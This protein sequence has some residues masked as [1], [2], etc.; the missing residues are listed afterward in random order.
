MTAACQVGFL[1][2]AFLRPDLGLGKTVV[3]H[4]RDVR[5][6]DI[7]ATAA[8]D[9]VEQVVVLRLVEV[10]GAGVPEDLLRQQL[11]RA[12]LDAFSTADARPFRGVCGH[13]V[14][15]GR[16]QAVRCLGH[17]DLVVLHRKAHHRAAEYQLPHR[18]AVSAGLRDHEIRGAADR[19][20]EVAGLADTAAGDR[21]H[22]LDQ[23]P[24]AQ[25]RIGHSDRGGDVLAQH[26][27]R[28]GQ[29]M[30]R[31]LAAGQQPDQLLLAT[32]RVK[33]W[34]DDDFG[35]RI[36][37]GGQRLAQRFGG[38]RLVV[39][40]T[41]QAL[42]G[43][44]QMAQDADALDHVGRLLTHQHVVAGDVGLALSGIDDQGV[45]RALAAGVDLDRCREGG[46]AEPDDAGPAD[47]FAQVGSGQGGVVGHGF[48]QV[49]PGILAVGL[50]HDTGVVQA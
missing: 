44:D 12:H 26:A 10:V 13:L 40:D 34:D 50:D 28:R 25:H 42:P 38:L 46:A 30:R 27:D 6:A 43:T 9:A 32:T 8:F 36:G 18:V 37:L 47:A 33:R 11:G 49:G 14:L 29:P 48:R 5:R 16:E 4:Q 22:A 1:A 24:A 2:L 41:D 31:Y 7:G 21:D 39:L 23:R 15:C 45:D 17:R 19:H 35:P 20:A 3:V